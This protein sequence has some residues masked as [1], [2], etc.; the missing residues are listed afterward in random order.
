MELAAG[1]ADYLLL[2]DADQTLE[3]RGPLPPLDADSYLLRYAGGLDYAVPRLVRGDRRWWYEGSTH[4]YLAADGEI[5]QQPLEGLLVHHHADSGTRAEKL[6]RD[7]GML[8][9]ELDERPDDQRAT[10][11][12]AQTLADAG[13]LD[14]AIALYRRRVELG[15][16]DEEVF[17][18]AY[19]AGVL[20]GESD[21]EAAMPLLA[22]AARLRPSR[23]EP[24][25]ELSRLARQRGRHREA[26]EYA[27][28]GLEVPYPEDLLFVHR[29]VYEWGLLFELAVAA[30]L[31]GEV[32]EALR[33]QPAPARRA[34]APS[35]VCDRRA[36]R[37]W[38]A[39]S[40]AF[41]PATRPGA[42]GPPPSATCS[43][44]GSSWPRSA[45]IS[46]RRGPSS[47]RRSPP[48]A[49]ASA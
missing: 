37:T 30:F 32:D 44:E 11:Y 41:P 43:A 9:A 42:P 34:Q 16:W 28:R 31:C 38:S 7:R 15:G 40:S 29:D 14:A 45:S 1:S 24:L 47:T 4:E 39:A 46:T 18:A 35:V 27:K 26:Y 19:R 48:T 25:H 20:K 6:E 49:T 17:Y 8:E 10:F 13:E 23:A 36:R 21:P 33:G 3:D 12:L 22:E 5:A 2:L